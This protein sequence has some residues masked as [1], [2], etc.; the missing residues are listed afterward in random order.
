[1]YCLYTEIHNHI[2]FVRMVNISTCSVKRLSQLVV[3]V[4][5]FRR[6]DGVG[7]PVDDVEDDEGERERSSRHSVD[8]ACSSFARFDVD[9]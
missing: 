1:M 6:R 9:S 4:G 3:R 7:D 5:L 2:V 8:V